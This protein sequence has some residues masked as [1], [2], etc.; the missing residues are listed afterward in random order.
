MIFKKQIH[1]MPQCMFKEAVKLPD[2]II[3]VQSAIIS[4]SK[5]NPFQDK[6]LQFNDTW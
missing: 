2:K 4:V 1:G 6:I 3:D 5:G